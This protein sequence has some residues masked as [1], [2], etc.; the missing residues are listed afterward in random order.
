MD[1]RTPR[2]TRRRLGLLFGFRRLPIPFNFRG[3]H[4]DLAV[5]R[6]RGQELG[7][8]RAVETRIGRLDAKKEA[9][10]ALSR[11]IGLTNLRSRPHDEFG[12]PAEP[13]SLLTERLLHARSWTK[14]ADPHA[15]H[16]M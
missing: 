5:R 10:L 15:L 9:V 2:S 4:H 11:W 6:Q 12:G 1:L 3:N 8:R 14:R 16:T 13:L 7:G